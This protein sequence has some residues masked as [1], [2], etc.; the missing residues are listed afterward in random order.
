[1]SERIDRFCENLRVKLTSVESDIAAIRE[2]L[3]SS[4]DSAQVEILKRRDAVATKVTAAKGE[5]ADARAAVADWTDAQKATTTE[6][7]D[8]WKAS[9]NTKLLSKRADVAEAY[10]SATMTI[11]MEALDEANLAALDA[12]LARAD[13]DEAAKAVSA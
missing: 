9:A 1:M 11:A 8:E 3:N 13:A 12:W 7:V 5:L 6:M 4:V 2:R 10:A